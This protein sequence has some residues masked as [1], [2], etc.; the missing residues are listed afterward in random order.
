MGRIG[1]KTSTRYRGSMRTI[2]CSCALTA[3][4]CPSRKSC[5]ISAKAALFLGRSRTGTSTFA[6]I[7]RRHLSLTL[8]YDKSSDSYWTSLDDPLAFR[9]NGRGAFG[10]HARWRDDGNVCGNSI[11]APSHLRIPL[12][13]PRI[14][15]GHSRGVDDAIRGALS[16][17]VFRSSSQYFYQ[18][19]RT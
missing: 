10:C 1:R 17:G 14:P 6:S 2:T 11:C 7:D 3:P 13:G 18:P 15:P 16:C 9:R 5:V 19:H 12:G 8:R 4:C